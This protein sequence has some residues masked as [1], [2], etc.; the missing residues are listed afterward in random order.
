MSSNLNSKHFRFHCAHPNAPVWGCS[1]GVQLYK[2]TKNILFLWRY[3]FKYL[4]T[5]QV[6]RYH[7]FDFFRPTHLFDDLQH[8]K[9]SKIANFW[10]HPPTS[11]MTYLKG[12]LD[13]SIL[14]ITGY[15]R[16]MKPFLIEI[17]NIWA[18]A[19]KLGRL[20]VGHLG[21]FRPYYQHPFWY[22]ESIAHVFHYSTIIST[23]NLSFNYLGLG[24]EFGPQRIRD[25]TFMCP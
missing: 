5:I 22:S 7:V 18:W 2:Q 6:L 17:Q 21:Y 12:P 24:F 19:D 25:L 23:K 14:W 20:I 15:G 10:P 4:G 8:C 1:F 13:N 11:L 9:S 3:Q 16:P